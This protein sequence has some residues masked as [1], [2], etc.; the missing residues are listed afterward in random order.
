[1]RL[2]NSRNVTLPRIGVD[3]ML[4][5]KVPQRNTAKDSGLHSSRRINFAST[6]GYGNKIYYFMKSGTFIGQMIMY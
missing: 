3:R 2:M 1:M 5:L 4:M 6:C